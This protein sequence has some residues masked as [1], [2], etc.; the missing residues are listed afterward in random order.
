[1]VRIGGHEGCA[2][3]VLDVVDEAATPY[4]LS[5]GIASE[6]QQGFQFPG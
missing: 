6:T 5:A 4:G 3:G 2:A 1:M